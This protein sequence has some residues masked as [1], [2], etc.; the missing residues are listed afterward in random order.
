MLM[1]T[2]SFLEAAL[3]KNISQGLERGEFSVL[4]QPQWDFFSKSI[5]GFEALARWHAPGYG[6]IPP[7]EFIPVAESSGGICSLGEW[8]LLSACQ[9][10]KQWQKEEGKTFTISVN[11]SGRQLEH[12]GFAGRVLEILSMTG[13]A[14][15][16]LELEITESFYIQDHLKILELLDCLREEGVRLAMDDFGT[17]YSSLH[18]LSRLP[19]DCLKIDQ[20][21]VR[22][23]G[24]PKTNAV[25]KGVARLAKE[26]GLKTIVEGI[27]NKDEEFTLWQLGFN[28]GQGYLLSPPVPAEKA[29]RFLV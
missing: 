4:Y 1:R 18:H 6:Q 24:S 5:T 26:M 14:P 3:G 13:L 22:F 11:V 28:Q 29:I 7:S 15:Q 17:G 20:S 25:V 27:E 23:L 16:Y 9:Q 2:R 8:V 21:F 10:A 12:I 19:L